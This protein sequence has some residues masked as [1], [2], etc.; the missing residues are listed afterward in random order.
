ME[1]QWIT[2]CGNP[3]AGELDIKADPAK[4]DKRVVLPLEEG[5]WDACCMALSIKPGR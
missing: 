5:Y 4:P 2:P 1:P 3:C